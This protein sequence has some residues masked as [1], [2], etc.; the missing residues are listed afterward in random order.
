[1][2]WPPEPPDIIGNNLLRAIADSHHTEHTSDSDEDTENRQPCAHP[3]LLNV[4]DPYG[5][6]LI[7]FHLVK[8]IPF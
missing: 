7:D 6:R 1:M 4:M 2:V 3:V 8:E 5:Y